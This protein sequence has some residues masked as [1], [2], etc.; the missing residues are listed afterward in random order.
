M[1]DILPVSMQDILY[2]RK[3][4]LRTQQKI[5]SE[6]SAIRAAATAAALRMLEKD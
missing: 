4:D 1:S 6:R 5:R 2:S 3:P